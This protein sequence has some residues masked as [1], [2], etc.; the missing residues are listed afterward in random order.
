MNEA[1]EWVFFLIKKK[2]KEKKGGRLL[3]QIIKDKETGMYGDKKREREK[4]IFFFFKGASLASIFFSH[5]IALVLARLDKPSGV[6]GYNRVFLFF[7]KIHFCYS[8]A[9]VCCWFSGSIT[10]IYRVFFLGSNESRSGFSLLYS[11]VRRVRSRL[12]PVFLPAFTGF[13]WLLSEIDR[14]LLGLLLSLTVL[15]SFP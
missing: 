15:L 9:F 4:K 14:V 1:N 13:D 8:M 11:R 7:C 5:W 12:W 6:S 10:G 3:K 2:T